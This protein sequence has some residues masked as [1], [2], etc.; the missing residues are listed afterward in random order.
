MSAMKPISA[1]RESGIEVIV[2]FCSSDM[3]LWKYA[4][5]KGCATGTFFNLRRV[6]K[7]QFEEP[8]GSGGRQVDYWFEEGLLAFTRQRELLRLRDKKLRV[9]SETDRNPFTKEILTNLLSD[10]P[11]RWLSLGMAKISLLVH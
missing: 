3:I 9:L 4:G 7:A 1:M 10:K 5:A 6:T 2:A 11:K 8:K